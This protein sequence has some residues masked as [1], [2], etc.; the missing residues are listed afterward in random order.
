M[1]GFYAFAVA[2][3]TLVSCGTAEDHLSSLVKPVLSCS[4][5]Q[6]DTCSAKCRTCIPGS[7]GV[8]TDMPVAPAGTVC[9]SSTPANR[10]VGGILSAICDPVETCDGVTDSCPADVVAPAGTPCLVTDRSY[11]ACDLPVGVRVCDDGGLCLARALPTKMCKDTPVGGSAIC[12][13]PNFCDGSRLTCP[14]A[15]APVGTDCGGG[16][17]CDATGHCR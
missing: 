2:A 12:A 15:W 10:A 8:C 14:I 7:G 17:S 1:R 3:V 6:I 16:K 5:Q 9:R 11:G 4:Q 13:P